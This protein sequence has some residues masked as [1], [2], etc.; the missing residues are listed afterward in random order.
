MAVDL[1]SDWSTLKTMTATWRFP[2]MCAEAV[3]F[4]RWDLHRLLTKLS[5]VRQDGKLVHVEVKRCNQVVESLN[6]H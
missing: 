6:H 2:W 4:W 3:V 1:N 5:G